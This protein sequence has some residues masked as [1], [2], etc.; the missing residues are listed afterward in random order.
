MGRPDYPPADRLELVESRL[1]RQIA[2]FSC[3]LER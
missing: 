1:G 3:W 2:V